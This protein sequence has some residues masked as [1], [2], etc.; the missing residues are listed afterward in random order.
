MIHAIFGTDVYGAV[1]SV[2]HTPVVTKFEMIQGI[3]IK[4]LESYFLGRLGKESRS[5]VPFIAEQIDRE[6]IGFPCNRINRLSVFA[7]YVRAVCAILV[8]ISILPLF[9][10][11][12]IRL[13]DP[14]FNF[15]SEKQ[16]IAIVLGGVL[17]GGL[18]LVFPTYLFTVIVPLR[19]RRI[20]HACARVLGIAADPANIKLEIANVMIVQ[21]NEFLRTQ[22]IPDLDAVLCRPKDHGLQVLDMLLVRT[23]AQIQNDGKSI[24]DEFNT[25]RLLEAMDLLTNQR[26]EGL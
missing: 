14:T 20:R 13:S 6:I 24:S 17:A 4:P 12:V 9:S 21:A 18:L 23:R 2:E 19:E 25:D 22:Q 15:D 5:G 10:L 3:P 8:L 1:R 11:V 16:I 7:T 26:R